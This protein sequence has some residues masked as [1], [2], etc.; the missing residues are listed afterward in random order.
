MTDVKVAV[1]LGDLE[2]SAEGD[3]TWV[4]QQLDKVLAKADTITSSDEKKPGDGKSASGKST[5]GAKGK[6]PP[7]STYLNNKSIPNQVAKFLATA[8]WLDERAGTPSQHT[9]ANVS[10]ALR[11]SSE[12]NQRYAVFGPKCE[13]RVLRKGWQAVPRNGRG[14]QV[15]R[16]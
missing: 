1:K 8:A 13:E 10:R 7:L 14:P 5:G 16:Y 15:T 11:P 12:T 6:V 2:F 9:T 4:G 3:K